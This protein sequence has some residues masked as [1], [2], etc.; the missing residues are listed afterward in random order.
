MKTI[1]YFTI[2]LLTLF[3]SIQAEGTIARK[4]H[5]IILM[6]TTQGEI[7]VELF[8]DSAPKAVENF[9]GHIANRYYNE[10]TFHRIIPNFMI[11][12][13]TPKDG[14]GGESI[15]GRPFEDEFDPNLKF[16]TPGLL[17]MVNAGPNSNGSQFFI[18]TVQTPWLNGLHT[19]F[20]QVIKGDDVVKKIEAMGSSNGQP[21]EEQKLLKIIVQ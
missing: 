4:K 18:T 15:W 3:S 14:S 1:S 9:L 8:P 12:C 7:K 11:Q 10:S 6:T 17:A 13:G 16:D 5:P 21:L 2:L 19:I 20:G